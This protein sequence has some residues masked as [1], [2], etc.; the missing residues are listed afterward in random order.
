MICL[1]T[2]RLKCVPFQCDVQSN[3]FYPFSPNEEKKLK[4]SAALPQNTKR[5][6]SCHPSNFCVVC[7]NFTLLRVDHRNWS[8][9]LSRRLCSSPP[10]L[11]RPREGAL[12]H[13]INCSLLFCCLLSFVI[14]LCLRTCRAVLSWC[15]CL[16]M[17]LYERRYVNLM[18]VFS[19]LKRGY[20]YMDLHVSK[21]MCVCES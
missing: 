17:A 7:P 14:S 8:S 5:A 15:V 20:M 6:P 12:F 13:C 2:L 3:T 10:A 9:H 19:W 4:A 18:C 21:G 11:W 1:Q 16:L